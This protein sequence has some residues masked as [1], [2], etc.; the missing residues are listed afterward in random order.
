M[1]KGSQA[2]IAG[3]PFFW[4][5]HPELLKPILPAPN[6]QTAYPAANTATHH[7]GRTESKSYSHE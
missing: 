5:M 2:G 1:F 7:Q 4:A 3:L 6:S